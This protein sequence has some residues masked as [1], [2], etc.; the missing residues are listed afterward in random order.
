MKNGKMWN[1]LLW[2]GQSAKPTQLAEVGKFSNAA[3]LNQRLEKKEI[4]IN[5]I[6]GKF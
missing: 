6:G 4:G 1:C 2:A 3:R 5:E